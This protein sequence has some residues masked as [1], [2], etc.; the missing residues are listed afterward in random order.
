VQNCDRCIGGREAT[1][2]SKCI[3]SKYVNPFEGTLCYWDPGYY[4]GSGKIGANLPYQIAFCA[5]PN[6][7]N[8]SGN[9]E[10]CDKCYYPYLQSSGKCSLTG[11][12][13]QGFD[14]SM[15]PYAYGKSCTTATCT[16]CYGSNKIC[17]LPCTDINC[18]DCTSD[19]SKCKIC[20]TNSVAQSYLVTDKCYLQA[21]LPAGYGIDKTK[22]KEASLCADTNCKECQPDHAGC[23]LCDTDNK[24]YLGTKAG[25]T[26]PQCQK[27]NDATAPFPM[28]YGP[29]ISTNRVERC[30]TT[31]C[32]TCSD[33]HT[34][35]KA[36]D[37]VS[38]P[39][40]VWYMGTDSKTGAKTCYSESTTPI[41]PDG[42]GPIEGG[43][44]IEL[45][46]LSNCK[47]CPKSSNICTECK[48]NDGGWYM[49]V[50]SGTS[51]PEC[52][53]GDK[54]P[55][56]PP[57]YGPDLA[58]LNVVPCTLDNC[59][60]CSASK[61][62]CTLCDNTGSI[63]W[64]LGKNADTNAAECQSSST[65]PKFPVGY[66]PN[67]SNNNVEVC[68]LTGCS[69]CP[70]STAT[71]TACNTNNGYFMGVKPGTSDNQCQ[72]AKDPAVPFPESYGPD[73]GTGT[74]KQCT[75]ANCKTCDSGIAVCDECLYDLG[76][77]LGSKSGSQECQKAL[78]A[79]SPFPIGYGPNLTNKLVEMC[80]MTGCSNCDDNIVICNF[81]DESKNY[82]MGDE[83]GVATCFHKTNKPFPEGYGP[84]IGSALIYVCTLANCKTCE[85]TIDTCDACKNLQG[86]YMG[87]KAGTADKECQSAT[88]APKFPTGY[89]PN[90][91]TLLVEQCSLDNCAECN[92]SKDGCTKCDVTNEWFLG[93]KSGS[94]Q[95]QKAG[96]TTAGFPEGFG[97]NLSNN[98]VEA[99]T[100]TGCKTCD[101]SIATCTACNEAAPEKWYIGQSIAGVATCFSKST[102]L[103]FLDGFGPKVGTA[104]VAPCTL[105]NCKLCPDTVDTCET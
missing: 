41:F 86:W 36:C 96:E 58:T 1:T 13:G 62:T 105:A 97:P 4:Q 44:E 53:S 54:A 3:N 51:D 38:S 78:H 59:Y 72:K 93:T 68:T 35:C 99:C 42:Y 40:T 101:D 14:T 57:K 24:W 91:S 74:V 2:C 23:T 49:G 50:K 17:D 73:S 48:D 88:T 89:G 25:T 16:S 67:T 85:N 76:W 84:K 92:D 18:Q 95:C 28:H 10:F 103:T 32:M 9:Y 11:A 46:K 87:T 22:V 20:K 83:S 90:L 70:D 102:P 21:N 7:S 63:K 31:G 45:C 34:V 33:D 66:G 30:A 100:M 80:K 82:F 8:C 52:Q 94:D 29:N 69:A 27:A 15:L 81:C 56:F 104:T 61:D 71:C 39:T 12:S 26:D 43:T 77:Y 98:K 6:C 37:N 75:L 55:M 60:T 64:Y 5:D 65:L 47:K 79:T 19:L